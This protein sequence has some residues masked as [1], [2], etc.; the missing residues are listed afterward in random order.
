[1]NAH[2]YLLD[3]RH[4]V[5]R[6][7]LLDNL[8]ARGDI[9][10]GGETENCVDLPPAGRQR[11]R[12]LHT[13]IEH[14]AGDDAILVVPLRVAWRIPHFARERK[15]R[16]SDFLWGDPRQPG[17]L[18]SRFILGRDPVRAQCLRG[19]PAALGDL[20]RRFAAQVAA[21][22][23]DAAAFAAFVVRQATLTLDGEERGIQGSRYKVPRFVGES[24][25]ASPAF[26]R[27]LQEMSVELGRSPA[28]V[29]GQ[30]RRYLR[31]MVASPS[32]LFL[33]L[34]D[35]F[36]RRLWL[37]GYDPVIRYDPAEF[38]RL[39]LTLRTHP[40]VLLFTHKTYGDAALPGLMLYANDLPMLHTFGGINLDLPVFGALMRR[41]GGI[42]IRRSFNDDAVYK[43]VL[44]KYV[45]FL[46]EKRF[47]M[48]W[49]LEGTRSRLGKLMPPRLGLLKYTVEAA[50]DAG[51]EDLHVVPFVTSFELIRDVDDYVAEQAG[52]AKKPE[53]LLWLL[54][55]AR[56][57]RRPMGRVRIDLGEPVVVRQPPAPDD[58]LALAKIAFNA[59]VHANRATPLTVTGVMCLVLLGMA[60]RGATAAELVK[61]V[62]VLAH[63]ARSRG[64]RLSEE[65]AADDPQDFLARLEALA[66]SGLLLHDGQGRAGVYALDPARHPVASYYRNTIVHHFLHKA[67]IELALAKALDGGGDDLSQSFWDETERLR[68]L[69]KFEFFYPAREQFRQELAAELER[70]DPRWREHLAGD[71]DRARRLAGRLQPFIAHAALLPY[72][73]GYAVVVDQLARLAP[74]QSLDEDRCVTRALREGRRAHLLRSISSEASI[75]RMLFGNAYRLAVNLGLAGDTTEES[76]GRRRALLRELQ[77]LVR[78]MERLRLEALA[79]AEEVMVAQGVR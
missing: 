64:I 22:G 26:A 21:D 47:P 28:D 61:F 1:M 60:P 20:R 75:G 42:F 40:T 30:A 15:L 11:T 65:L 36:D 8:R 67:F 46:L 63:W 51:L 25:L 71:L 49:A 73:E 23:N 7:V 72:A 76:L 79:C 27:S 39:R 55:Y 52:R 13:L 78:R 5:E 35:W 53:S 68:E 62:Q 6:R 16:I 43:L 29:R 57:V 74:G 50:R 59:A 44:R 58:R 48:S 33:D 66:A 45:A 34:R 9:V 70:T 12:D 2:L 38:E 41:S 10:A 56:G 18:R 37:R 54:G 3:A 4:A 77:A 14:L 19:E 17:R 31:E 32:A 24:I 69:F